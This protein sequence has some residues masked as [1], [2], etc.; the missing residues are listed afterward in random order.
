[1]SISIFNS[2]LALSHFLQPEKCRPCTVQWKE[3]ICELDN[4]QIVPLPTRSKISCN[5]WECWI[6][7]SEWE[8]CLLLACRASVQSAHGILSA[9]SVQF[10]AVVHSRKTLRLPQF[11][12]LTYVNVFMWLLLF[13]KT[14]IYNDPFSTLVSKEPSLLFPPPSAS[15]VNILGLRPFRDPGTFFLFA[16]KF[17]RVVISLCSIDGGP[18]M[19][20]LRGASLASPHLRVGVSGGA[21]PRNSVLPSAFLEPREPAFQREQNHGFYF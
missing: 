14:V 13:Q 12:S 20:N 7:L 21:P 15:G 18:L 16:W 4:Y 1:M 5:S 10:I 11:W 2:V 17:Q 8:T 6:R 3:L 19:I 9:P